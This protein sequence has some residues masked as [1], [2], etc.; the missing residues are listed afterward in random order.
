VRDEDSHPYKT[1]GKITDLTILM[2]FGDEI[3]Q[4]V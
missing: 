3:A 2:I 4:P 1:M